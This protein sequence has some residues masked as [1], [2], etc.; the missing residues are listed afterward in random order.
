MIDTSTG[1]LCNY[2]MTCKTQMCTRNKATI[3]I[4]Q[5]ACSYRDKAAFHTADIFEVVVEQKAILKLLL[6]LGKRHL[7]KAPP[8][9][10]I[11]CIAPDSVFVTHELVQ[12]FIESVIPGIKRCLKQI[13]LLESVIQLWNIP[14]HVTRPHNCSLLWQTTCLVKY[15][16]S[17]S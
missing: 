2:R 9:Y 3:N 12:A 1:T 7:V 14:F 16:H 11:E 10:W 15:L 4:S 5:H 8:N 6:W 13:I 17:H